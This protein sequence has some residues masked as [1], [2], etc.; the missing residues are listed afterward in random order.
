MI[1][2]GNS[3]TFFAL[4]K[5][6]TA[7]SCH[8]N[9]LEQNMIGDNHAKLM[10]GQVNV[11]PPTSPFLVMRAHFT[12]THSSHLWVLD[13]YYGMSQKGRCVTGFMPP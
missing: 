13:Q 6:K 4:N 5:V 1:M 3:L 11:D 9:S 12:C 10:T 8:G 2:S 7:T